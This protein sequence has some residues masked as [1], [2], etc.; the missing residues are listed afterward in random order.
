MLDWFNRS[1]DS[2]DW[3]NTEDGAKS[4]D[5]HVAVSKVRDKDSL[6]RDAEEHK[7]A[8][9]RKKA[10][11]ET[12]RGHLQK[13][14]NELK[15]FRGVR[16]KGSREMT[17][18][19]EEVETDT[20]ERMYSQ[21]V[22]DNADE[23]QPLKI[24]HLKTFWEK[25]NTG[26]KILI[27]KS[28]TPGD[29]RP[30]SPLLSV[31][32]ES[33]M[34][35]ISGIYSGQGTNDKY[36]SNPWDD[37][38]QQL[39]T[40]SPTSVGV[41]VHLN[42]HQ[43]E[44]HLINN[45]NQRNTD[46]SAYLKILSSPQKT[47][48]GTLDAETLCATKHIPS[49]RTTI[50][51]ELESVYGV[52]PN[53]QSDIISKVSEPAPE[54]LHLKTASVSKREM[55]P[56]KRLSLDSEKLFSLG[57]SPYMNYNPGDN[58]VPVSTN[59]PIQRGS[60]EDVKRREGV[61]TSVHSSISPKRRDD[62]PNK[63]R[64]NSPHLNRQPLAHQECTAERI[65]QLKLFWEQERNKPVF[66]TGRSKGL[67]VNR[68]SNHA[69]LNKRFTKSEFDL[70]SVGNVLGSDE[71]DENKNHP[72][73]TVLPMH[74]RLDKLS[75]SLGTSRKQFN[76]L[77]EFWYEATTDSR[78]LL[79]L[80][81]PKSPKRK[82]PLSAQLSSQELKACD[83]ESHRFN[84]SVEKTKAAVMKSSPQNR[85]KSPHDRHTG[86]GSRMLSDCKNNLPN[87]APAESG[88]Q[89]QSKRSSKDSNREEKST[90]PL[91]SSGKE[92]RA[93]KNR[94]DS[95][96]TSSSRGNSLRRATSMFALSAD[97]EKD[98]SQLRMDASPVHS[99]SRKHRQ[100]T[101]KG[102]VSRRLS[103]ES[104]TVAPR[105]RAFVPTD[106]RHYLG[107][108][109]NTSIDISLASAVTDEGSDLTGYELD[110][111]GP[112]KVST[113]VSSEERHSRKGNKTGQRPTWANYSGSDTGPES[114]VSSVSETWSNSRTSSFRKNQLYC[115][116]KDL[117]LKCI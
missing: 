22:K 51:P 34:P 5:R 44:E 64:T 103:E 108:T 46:T 68:G 56:M 113:P 38:E 16:R 61:D 17:E 72:N 85:S 15:E 65:K 35:F 111:G 88:P 25:S 98:L 114:S 77:R 36:T 80:D 49:E 105:A 69:K 7:G 81:K 66:Y 27:S 116:T 18:T 53:L 100:S 2:S 9:E 62:A 47:S 57:N 101:D 96:S 117:K 104:E 26:P 84:Q 83:A 102:A 75:P 109:D 82:E 40:S 90:K 52:K 21:D 95:F 24:S 78:G 94:K 12:K 107:M 93:P 99:Q 71:E 3:L 110:V 58:D 45:S 39:V 4:S 54:E 91:A 70:R 33:D 73:F 10:T 8:S 97:D 92:V 76:T 59:V 42:N 29:K 48:R 11:P 74:Q 87:Y 19:Q 6:A 115:H 43:Q 37:R 13:L 20:R 89:R 50:Y 63:D 28:V 67:G 112:V 41:T 32:K 55:D 79:T 31:E 60:S 14:T 86:C 106:Y 30:N 1:L 23:S